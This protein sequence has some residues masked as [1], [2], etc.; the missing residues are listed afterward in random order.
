MTEPLANVSDKPGCPA[1]GGPPVSSADHDDRTCPLTRTPGLVQRGRF[2]PR[3][4]RPDFVNVP[5]DEVDPWDTTATLFNVDGWP[6][7]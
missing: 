1:C 4:K 2:A 5:L 7:P 3:P 6:D